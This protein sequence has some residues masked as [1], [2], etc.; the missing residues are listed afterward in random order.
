M[1]PNP[2]SI[3]NS[4]CFSGAGAPYLQVSPFPPIFHILT[5]FP[6]GPWD[7]P[8]KVTMSFLAPS[9]PGFL[10]EPLC[11]PPALASSRWLCACWRAGV[12]HL[13]GPQQA[14]KW[15]EP[16]RTS[17]AIRQVWSPSGQVGR[18]ALPATGLGLG[19][20]WTRALTV[21]LWEAFSWQQGEEKGKQCWLVT[22][23]HHSYR[24][25]FLPDSPHVVRG[26]GKQIKAG[27]TEQRDQLQRRG[28]TMGVMHELIWFHIH[29]YQLFYPK[30]GRYQNVGATRAR[31]KME[32]N[33][34]WS[35]KA[36][37]NTPAHP[38]HEGLMC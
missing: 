19:S 11:D 14:S 31:E 20:V 21:C 10:R 24:C 18:T 3:H 36:P 7:V 9:I 38:F 26:P 12:S 32:R 22:T 34:G 33:P 15:A 35:K 30:V 28:K 16:G 5:S 25:F 8:L 37:F 4:P 2:S 1:C 6:F 17:S 29:L 13:V 27:E 23:E